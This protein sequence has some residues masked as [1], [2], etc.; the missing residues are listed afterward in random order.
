VVFAHS[1]LSPVESPYAQRR[2]LWIWGV[3]SVV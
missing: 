3:D 2:Q 1:P